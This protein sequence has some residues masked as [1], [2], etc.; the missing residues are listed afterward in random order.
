MCVHD[1]EVCV[2]GRR[3]VY[4]K[5]RCVLRADMCVHE[6]EVCVEGRRCVYT[7]GRYVLRAGDLCMFMCC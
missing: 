2:E 6:G 5:G 1:G 3:C 7:K 4:M